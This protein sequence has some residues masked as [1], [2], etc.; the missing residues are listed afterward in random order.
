MCTTTLILPGS[1]RGV[2][3]RLCTVEEGEGEM[4]GVGEGASGRCEGLCRDGECVYL[5]F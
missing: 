3:K 1:F 2:N 5:L 4:C